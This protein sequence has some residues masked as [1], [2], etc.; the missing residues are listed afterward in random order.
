MKN[1][2]LWFCALAMVA[3]TGAVSAG[4]GIP[5]GNA[6]FY[7]S[8]EFIYSHTDNLFLTD[9]SMGPTFSD[10]YW[11]VRPTLGF[12]FPFKQSYVRLDVGY[13]YKDYNDYDLAKHNSWWVGFDSAFKFSNGSKLTLKNNFLQGVQELN[14]VDPGYEATWG[15]DTFNYN[16]FK[17]AY[18][19]NL[20]QYNSM[21]V[22]GLWNYTDFKDN[23][24]QTQPFY[25]YEQLGAGVHWKYHLNA[26]NNFLAQYTYMNSKDK[27]FYSWAWGSID[28]G[29]NYN[30][31]QLLVGWEGSTS[32]IFSGYAKAGYQEM[33][34]TQNNYADFSGL[35][36]DSA[37]KF[38]FTELF[39][40]DL[41]LYRQPYQSAYN[42]NNYYVAEGA[43]AQL[44]QQVTRYFFW[45]AGYNYQTNNYPNQTKVDTM[46]GWYVVGD[47]AWFTQGQDRRDNISRL[48]G[49]LGFHITRQFSL[50]VNYWHEDRDSNIHFYD[51]Y[52]INREPYSYKEDR[53]SFQAQLG[54]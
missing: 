42:V 38:N 53:F 33:N 29:R 22:F 5:M 54:W 4:E 26:R 32:K 21:G 48:F 8:V 50:R 7:P 31:N 49:E 15:N 13:Q 10:Y 34:F 41:N 30:S 40:L 45:T 9:S 19:F 1:R 20:N 35:V 36:V 3:F 46:G 25:G 52:G 17:V 27:N 18:D 47:Y 43:K 44:H 12:E 51:I 37:L 6:V 23:G 28:P 39:K 24:T 14:K 11:A 16:E 2:V